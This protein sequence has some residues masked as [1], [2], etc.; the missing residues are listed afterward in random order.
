MHEITYESVV[1]RLLETI[2]EFHADQEDVRDHLA[3]LVF[4]DLRR[5]VKSALETSNN[6]ELLKR[7]FGFIEESVSGHD[8]RVLDVMRDSFLEGLA[9]SPDHLSRAEK[10]MGAS[11]LKLLQEARDYLNP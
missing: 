4:E 11:T 5:F 6:G 1:Q 8:I 7:V 2:P 10:Y 3:H 9:D